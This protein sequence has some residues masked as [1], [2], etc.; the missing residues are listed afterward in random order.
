MKL[1]VCQDHVDRGIDVIVDECET[2]PNLDQ[3]NKDEQLSTA[4]EYCSESATYIVANA[5]SNT[6]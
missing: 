1:F 5:G 6:K 3:L 2:F 4:C